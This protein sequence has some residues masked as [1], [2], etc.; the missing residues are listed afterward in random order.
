MATLAAINARSFIRIRSTPARGVLAALLSLLALAGCGGQSTAPAHAHRRT[1]ERPRPRGAPIGARRVSLS[2]RSLFN[3]PAPVRDPASARLGPDAFVLLG[4]LTA[5]DTSTDQVI[6]GGLR[7][8]ADRA[9]LPNAQHDAQAAALPHGVYVFG[10]G[11]YT[12]YSHV[13]AYDPASGAITTAGALP[14]AASD[15][16]VTGDG[17]TGYVVGGFDGVDW[18]DTI[19]AY[20]PGDP[21]RVVARLPVAL[22]YAA[23]AYVDGYVLVAGGSTPKGTNDRIFR[24][25]P[26]TRAVT[27]IGQLPTGI[28]HAG[29]GVIGATMYLVGGR[30][31][32]ETDRFADV[33]AIDPRTGKVRLTATLPQP[34]SDA[35]VVSLGDRLIV[36]GGSAASGT[37]AA[38]GELIVAA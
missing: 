9:A 24:Y 26:H 22:R 17:S 3:L 19:L 23:A 29:A 8:A 36:A 7:G 31:E 38:V 30:G 12:Q 10:G 15:V 20:T 35:G 33:W 16:A 32:T 34:L 11:Q 21:V 18:L 25:D 14:A 27:T 4:G 37:V 6:V 28:T 13:L 1:G 5:A 2:Y